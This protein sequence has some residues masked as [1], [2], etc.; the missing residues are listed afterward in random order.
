MTRFERHYTRDD[1]AESVYQYIV[2]DAPSGAPAITVRLDYDRTDAVV[3]LGLIGPDRF[4]G[5]SGG[6]RSVVSVTPTW[7][8]PGYIPGVVAGGWQVVL[9]LHRVGPAGVTVYV[10]VD[11]NAVDPPAAAPLP[12]RP[13]RPPRRDLPASAGRTWLACDFH[14]HTVHSDGGLEIAE[15]AVLAAVPW[16]RR[17]RGHRP[18]HGQPPSAPGRCRCPRRCVAAAWPGGHDGPRSCELLRDA[19]VDRLP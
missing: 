12:P 8:T 10:D 3:D 7:A 13:E 15:L 6:E 4:G 1:R 17:A 9:G 18:Q 16:P 2:V 19:P 14:S 5:W 11:T